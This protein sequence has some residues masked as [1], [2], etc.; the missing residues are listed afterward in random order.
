M[1]VIAAHAAMMRSRNRQSVVD[2][3][4]TM[5]SYFPVEEWH[6]AR[7]SSLSRSENVYWWK[8]MLPASR[9]IG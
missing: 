7:G 2:R 8:V 9:S 5:P 4:S 6:F 1:T 3:F